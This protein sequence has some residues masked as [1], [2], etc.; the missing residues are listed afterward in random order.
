MI[1]PAHAPGVARRPRGASAASC[2]T[3]ATA[4][5][6][7]LAEQARAHRAAVDAAHELRRAALRAV[8][9]AELVGVR[10][11]RAPLARRS[12][13]SSPT[14]S[15][16]RSWRR[17]A[18]EISARTGGLILAPAAVRHH[19]RRRPRRPRARRARPT[20]R[21]STRGSRTCAV[22]ASTCASARRS[23]GD[24]GGRRGA[25]AGVTTL[26]GR[27]RSPPTSTSPRCPSRSCGR[28][29]GRSCAARAAPERPRPSRDAV[30]ERRSCSTSTATSRSSTATRSTSTRS[31]R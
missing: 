13:S 31:G 20:R 17:A 19:A 30:D 18:R 4:L 24:R 15:R 29:L 23:Q 5:G 6:I 11:R 9:A 28:S 8:G 12:R 21:G 26:G 22:A 16:A 7:P 25:I 1:A 10:R 3:A 2:S 14:G 27:R